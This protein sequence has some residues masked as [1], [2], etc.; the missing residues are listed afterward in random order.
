MGCPLLDPPLQ[1]SATPACSGV[2]QPSPAGN[3][4]LHE[5]DR[6]CVHMSMKQTV[7]NRLLSKD[8]YQKTV[9]NRLSSTD[10][11]QQTVK[12]VTLVLRCSGRA[13]STPVCVSHIGVVYLFLGESMRKHDRKR[14][15]SVSIHSNDLSMEVLYVLHSK[16]GIA[17]LTHHWIWELV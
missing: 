11:H 4:C 3:V 16:I 12:V 9:I 13:L 1:G 5:T 6:L 17:S 2:S 15:V 7:I 14:N 8:C 10:C